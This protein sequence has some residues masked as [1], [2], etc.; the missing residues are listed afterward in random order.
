MQMESLECGAACLG[1]ILACYGRWVPLE[2]LR[3]EC[4]VSR[5]GSRSGNILRAARRYGLKAKGMAYSAEALLKN[6]TPP[7]ILF[8]NFTH[9]VVFTGKKGRHYCLN[10][11]ARGQI[12]VSEK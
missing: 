1:M 4:G 5:D 7:C 8:W 11:P 6:V 10:D 3:I 12:K 2:Q 9:Y